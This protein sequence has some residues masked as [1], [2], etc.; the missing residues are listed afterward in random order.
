MKNKLIVITLFSAAMFTLGCTK[1]KKTSTDS[2]ISNTGTN[3]TALSLQDYTFA[4]KA[5]FINAVQMQLTVI[6]QDLDKLASQVAKSAETVQA[7]ANPELQ[8][9]RDQAAQL[10]N[11]LEALNE[12]TEPTWNQVKTRFNKAD[13]A[14]IDEFQHARESV[15]DANAP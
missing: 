7:Q 14:M 10:N 5:Q 2:I 1:D 3:Q 6:N 13:E 8:T 11:Q 15:V 4:Q 9:L 12:A